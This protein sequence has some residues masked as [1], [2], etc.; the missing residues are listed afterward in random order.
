MVVNVIHSF[1]GSWLMYAILLIELPTIIIFLF[2]WE[3]G[4]L[5]DEGIWVILLVVGL[6][7]GTLA[8][9][10]NVKLILRV[11][12]YG[13]SF[14]NPPFLNRWK[15]FSPD[16]I[17]AIKVKETDGITEYGGLGLRF[18]R[19]ERA[20]IFMADH[21]LELETGQKKYV[22]STEKPQEI[23]EILESWDA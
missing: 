6:I 15:K 20:Y 9:I 7:I 2:L 11:D 18:G 12:R 10:I 13:V 1:K 4:H 17:K 3:K 16:Q 23:Q 22:F 5:G 14:K 8:L 19:K 21:V